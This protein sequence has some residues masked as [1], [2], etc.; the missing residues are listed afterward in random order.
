MGYFLQKDP[1]PTEIGI[2]RA[3][4]SSFRISLDR[5]NV[6]RIRFT[7][8]H[9]ERSTINCYRFGD[10][11]VWAID[12]YIFGLFFGHFLGQ[13]L[14]QFL[15]QFLGRFLGPPCRRQLIEFT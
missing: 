13:F 1:F 9:Q 7:N 14:E 11:G 5:V 10:G 12:M 15:E 3:V 2:L 6:I 8:C 4:R